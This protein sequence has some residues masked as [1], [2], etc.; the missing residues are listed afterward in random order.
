MRTT[1][2]AQAPFR[3][4]P[5]GEVALDLAGVEQGCALGKV[6]RRWDWACERVGLN[7]CGQRKGNSRW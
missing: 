2:T 5:R 7:T 4:R 3:V 1:R 6:P